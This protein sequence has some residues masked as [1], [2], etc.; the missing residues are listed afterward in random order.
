[1]ADE[2]ASLESR[3]RETITDLFSPLCS[4]CKD[5]CCHVDFCIA[6]LQSPWLTII[7]EI[8]NYPD[9]LYDREKG[10]L[11]ADGCRLGVGRP[12]FCYEFFCPPLLEG[13]KDPRKKYATS[14]LGMLM[15]H[16]G[17]V[18]LSWKHLVDIPTLEG[19]EEIDCGLYQNHILRAFKI[20]N[21]CRLI[22][23]KDCPSQE[24][25]RLMREVQIVP[26]YDFDSIA[27][28]HEEVRG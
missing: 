17:R 10:W 9:R 16:V 6:S 27:A 18:G 25:L 5:S 15:C 24:H 12:P 19:I 14:V 1:M 7:R 28:L 21:A 13:I 11:T 22:L 2:Y 4:T 26:F 20:L 23:K 3:V 8:N